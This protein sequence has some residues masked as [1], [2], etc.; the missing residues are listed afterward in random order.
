L[1]DTYI[2][3]QEALPHIRSAAERAAALDPRSADAHAMLGIVRGAYERDYA[4]A[5]SEF[6]RALAVDTTNAMASSGYAWQLWSLGLSDS[7]LAVI[8]R[9]L[10]QNPLSSLLLNPAVSISIGAG[11]M[12]LASAYCRRYAELG[13][14]GGGCPAQFLEAVS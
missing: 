2:A 10:R 12:D 5:E 8:N 1:A 9:A 14:A 6:R 4:Q 11:K 3:P 13:S 7:A